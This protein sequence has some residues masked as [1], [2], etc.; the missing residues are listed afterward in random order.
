MPPGKKTKRVRPTVGVFVTSPMPDQVWQ[1]VLKDPET[2]S[3]PD[4]MKQAL[5][6]FV[7]AIP[8]VLADLLDMAVT[9]ESIMKAKI[10]FLRYCADNGFVKAIIAATP[11]ES[12]WLIGAGTAASMLE[13]ALTAAISMAEQIAQDVPVMLAQ[14]GTTE[15]ELLASPKVGLTGEAL[16]LYDKSKLTIGDLLRLQP[17]IIIK[18]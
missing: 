2:A 13:L 11:A 4:V 9:V 6:P 8:K 18:T 17:M 15:R 16:A 7:E 12:L 5:R 10:A 1:G 3:Q 14:K